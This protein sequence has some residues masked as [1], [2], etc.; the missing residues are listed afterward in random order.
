MLDKYHV[1]FDYLKED[2]FVVHLP[3]KDIKFK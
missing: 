3:T 2:T 1:T